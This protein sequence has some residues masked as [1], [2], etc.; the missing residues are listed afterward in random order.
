MLVTC[1]L[2]H[3]WYSSYLVT[4]CLLTYNYMGKLSLFT[5][6]IRNYTN[7]CILWTSSMLLYQETVCMLK[8][9]AK[10]GHGHGAFGHGIWCLPACLKNS[11]ELASL[12]Q[13]KR[14]L[15]L[16]ERGQLWQVFRNTCRNKLRFVYTIEPRLSGTLIN[17]TAGELAPRVR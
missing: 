10:S 4:H 13:L 12:P 1:Y 15:E 5:V 3:T 8:W 2:S 7:I 11:M 17:R 9:S 16:S 6:I 14:Q